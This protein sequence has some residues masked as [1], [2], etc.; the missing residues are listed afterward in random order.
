VVLDHSMFWILMSIANMGLKP[1]R[2]HL[3]H[4]TTGIYLFQKPVSQILR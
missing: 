2:K 3:D 1:T 4:N